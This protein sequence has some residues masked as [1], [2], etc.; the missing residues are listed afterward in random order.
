MDGERFFQTTRGKVVTSLRRRRAASAVDLAAEFGVT[1]NAIR[2]HLGALERDGL[3]EERPVKRGPTKPTYE[4]SLTAKAQTLFPQRYGK[5]LDQ[6]LGV[7]RERGGQSA[8]DDVFSAIGQ[9]SARRLNERLG[10]GGDAAAR[11]AGLTNA[12]RE[13]GVDA[14]FEQRGDTFVVR[15]HNCP[16]AN[17]VASHP[18]V[19][20]VIHTVFDEVIGG[21]HKQVES[22]ATGGSECRFE[23][24]VLPKRTQRGQT[25]A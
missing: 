23:L 14:E 6:V 22:L 12:L 19:C 16:Y 1:P 5:M 17:T 11:V 25:S 9:K 18:E 13:S 3:V 4:F 24:Q 15:E 7:I 8:V 20:S 10:R 2:Q 21:E